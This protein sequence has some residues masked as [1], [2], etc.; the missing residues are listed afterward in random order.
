M[1]NFGVIVSRESVRHRVNR[2]GR[3]LADCIKRDRPNPRDQMVSGRSGNHM[4][5]KA[6]W[7]WCAVDAAGDV[8]DILVQPRRLTARFGDPS[9]VVTDKLRSDIKPIHD[10]APGADHR[11]HKGLNNRA[12]VSHR[13]TRRR[14]KIMGVQVTPAGPKISLRS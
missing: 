14:E 5:G 10:L 13:P 12:E 9:V 1:E 6:Y 7:L 8:R 4:D 3:Y 2:F 11:A